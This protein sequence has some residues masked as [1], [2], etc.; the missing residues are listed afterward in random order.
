[1][2]FISYIYIRRE[3]LGLGKGKYIHKSKEQKVLSE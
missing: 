2:L 1:M 3:R